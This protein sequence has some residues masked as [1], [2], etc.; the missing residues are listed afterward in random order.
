MLHAGVP[1]VVAMQFSILDSSG[2]VLRKLD[3]DLTAERVTTLMGRH[4]L[5]SLYNSAMREKETGHVARARRRLKLLTLVGHGAPPA[6][7]GP[8]R[9]RIW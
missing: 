8:R 3:S 1:A 6:A 5:T 7:W 2:K 9:W 4:L